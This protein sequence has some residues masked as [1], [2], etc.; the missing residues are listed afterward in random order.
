MRPLGVTSNT[1]TFASKGTPEG[2][3]TQ[4]RIKNAFAEITAENVTN[5]KKE[6]DPGTGSTGDPKQGEP[7]RPTARHT[8]VKLAK[9]KERTLKAARGK[10]K[11]RVIYKGIPT[12]L[13]AD[14]SA[15]SLQARG[16]GMM[17]L[18]G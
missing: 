9:V 10:K 1:P 15:E 18:E 4:K 7:N 5:L 17:Y 11:K 14:F 12:R 16:S 13:S 6:T 3:E 2:K 8:I